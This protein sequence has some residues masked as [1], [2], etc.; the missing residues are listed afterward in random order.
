MNVNFM[1]TRISIQDVCI[2]QV[3]KYGSFIE[4]MSLI[5]MKEQRDIEIFRVKIREKIMNEC[6]LK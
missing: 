1:F 6:V 4:V 5:K 3:M 2:M